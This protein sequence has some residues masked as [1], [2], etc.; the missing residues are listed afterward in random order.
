MHRKLNIL[1]KQKYQ[2]CQRFF[3]AQTKNKSA[4]KK[5]VD[6]CIVGC[7][8]VGIVLATILRNKFHRSCMILERASKLQDHPKAHYLGFR[9]CEIL[10]DL[11]P[12][13]EDA[14]ETQLK[15][16]EDWKS[17][18]YTRGILDEPFARVNHLS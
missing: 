11:D 2:N 6:I 15:E 3:A 17:Y 5:E 14:L 16:L 1:T 10:S 7:G 12:R 8:P 9:T 13:I 4:V 18:D